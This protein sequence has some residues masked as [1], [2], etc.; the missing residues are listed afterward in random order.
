M[1]TKSQHKQTALYSCVPTIRVNLDFISKCDWNALLKLFKALVICSSMGTGKTQGII[2]LISPNPSGSALIIVHRRS[3]AKMI[4]SRLNRAFQQ[5]GVDVTFVN[6]EGVSPKQ[7]RQQKH[8]VICLNSLPKLIEMGCE[9]PQYDLVIMDEIEQQLAH[10]TGDTFKGDEA[11]NAYHILKAILVRANNVVGLD[12]YATESLTVAWLSS[13]VG[14]NQVQ[15]LVNEYQPVRGDLYMWDNLYQVIHQ[16]T[17]ALNT[18]SKPIVIATSSRRIAKILYS[19]FSGETVLTPEELKKIRSDDDLSVYEALLDSFYQ[20]QGLGKNKVEVVHGENSD[21]KPVQS[22]F[23]NI[24]QRVASLRVLIY[25]SAIGSGI[26]IQTPVQAVFGLF[27]ANTLPGDEIHQMLGRCRKASTFHVWVQGSSIQREDRANPLLDREYNAI[28]NT[29]RWFKSKSR[30]TWDID[31]D[32]IACLNPTHQAYLQ[33]WCRVKAKTNY[34]LNNIQAEFLRLA[35]TEFTIRRLPNQQTE[36][37][38]NNIRII[39]RA[40]KEIDRKLILNSTSIDVKTYQMLRDRGE[41]TPQLTAGYIRGLIEG[42]Y[43]QLITPELYEHYDEGRGIGR[44]HTFLDFINTPEQA[45]QQDRDQD[46]FGVAIPNRKH[47]LMRR[48]LILK[49]ITLVFGNVEQLEDAG[50]VSKRHIEA[51]L[52][53][54]TAEN[55]HQLWMFFKWRVGHDNKPVSVLRRLLR[56][57]GLHLT[58]SYSG[59]SIGKYQ[60]DPAS[61]ADMTEYALFHLDFEGVA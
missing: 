23:A 60:I 39:G 30:V 5:A 57:M 8:L 28:E 58:K 37:L 47:H 52:R 19:Y 6:Y 29:G 44:L 35:G 9:I 42:G 31:N 32:G 21:T 16:A 48:E 1:T 46:T 24:N 45:I 49:A 38:Q 51:A 61:L 33:F 4:T 12:A 59:Q 22:L 7:L 10:L 43:R 13:V 36:Q 53:M 3:L 27:S 15:F 54:F 18:S 55:H 41:A 2:N 50:Y 17:E 25:T 26:D 56:E 40:Y 20:G 34:S 14:D 11:V